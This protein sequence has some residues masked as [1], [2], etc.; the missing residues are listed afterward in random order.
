ME[1]GNQDGVKWM[2]R[3]G[4][5]R[6][7]GPSKGW[8]PLTGSQW[9]RAYTQGE[10]GLHTGRGQS[11]LIVI[12]KSVISGLTSITVIIL[13]T[14]NLQFQG[15]FVPISLRPILGIVAA[16]VIATVWSSCGWL[17]PPGGGFSICKTT[18]RIWLR[19]LSVVLEKELKVLDFAYWLNYYYLVSFDYF[20]LFLHV[21][22]S[23][24]K[25]TL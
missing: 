10:R 8:L 5:G 16:Y 21:L 24:I 20:S 7:G 22:N 13:G 3:C 1:T 17:L 12:L 18:H 25:V 6:G 2:G 4:V 15:W 9:A 23:L 19:I 14:I 11:A